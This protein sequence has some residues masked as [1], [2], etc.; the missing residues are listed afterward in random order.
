[1]QEGASQLTRLVE[2]EETIASIPEQAFPDISELRKADSSMRILIFTLDPV[3]IDEHAI[4]GNQ[5]I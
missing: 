3:A 5:F 2:C 1:L 4:G